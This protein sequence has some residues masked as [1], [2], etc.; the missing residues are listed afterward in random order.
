ML[1]SENITVLILDDESA[2]KEN[3]TL[4]LEAEGFCAYSHN[5]AESA[6]ESIKSGQVFNVGIIDIRLPGMNGEEFMLEASK[7]LPE[8]KFL[9][10]TGSIDFEIKKPFAEIGI[11]E[12]DIFKKPIVRISSLVNRIKEVL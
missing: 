7:L 4:F 12:N 9:I 1:N 10:H 8:M 3:L 5:T 6:L 11:T 2:I